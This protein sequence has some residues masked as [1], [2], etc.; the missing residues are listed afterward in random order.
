MVAFESHKR[1]NLKVAKWWCKKWNEPILMHIYDKQCEI[2]Q[3]N[4]WKSSNYQIQ[5]FY[6]GTSG[7]LWW[8]RKQKSRQTKTPVSKKKSNIMTHLR[9]HPVKGHV[10]G[11]PK[12]YNIWRCRWFNSKLLKSTQFWKHLEAEMRSQKKVTV[13]SCKIEAPYISNQRG[14]N[15]LS[16]TL[17]RYG[18]S[19]LQMM[20]LSLFPPSSY[21]EWPKIIRNPMC[22]TY[23]RK[24]SICSFVWH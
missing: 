20:T 17:I 19:I 8:K 21:F 24:L 12:M 1:P 4:Q 14:T 18:A 16:S 11:F 22:H 15:S 5:C 10:Q 23:S 13:T 3:K 2:I 9:W 7:A 6:K